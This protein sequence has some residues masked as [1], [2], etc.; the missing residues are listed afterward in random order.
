MHEYSGLAATARD[1]RASGC[2]PVVVAPF[3]GTIHDPAAWADLVA[4]LGGAPVTLVWPDCDAAA[5][6]DRLVAR[7]SGND[8]AKLAAFEAFV[9]RMRPGEPPAVAHLR[10]D[11]RGPLAAL[12]AQLDAIVA[13]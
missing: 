6:R 11:N 1:I 7:A 4:D 12:P 5:L 10:V 8:V 9:A 13:A 2:P 3:T